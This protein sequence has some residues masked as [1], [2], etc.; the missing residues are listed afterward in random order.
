MGFRDAIRCLV[1]WSQGEKRL[2]VFATK[3]AS[4]IHRPKQSVQL[5]QHFKYSM[6]QQKQQ[7]TAESLH[8]PQEP[9]HQIRDVVEDKHAI[10]KATG[11]N[12]SYLLEPP[13]QK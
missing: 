10:I 1:A 2:V 12:G 11:W 9:A 5:H 4:F 7:T 6:S 13:Y 3:Y 8:T